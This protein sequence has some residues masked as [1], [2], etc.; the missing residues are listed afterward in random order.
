MSNHIWMEEVLQDL[1]VYCEANQLR[2]TKDLLTAA[3]KVL[4]TEGSNDDPIA[5]KVISLNS[6]KIKRTTH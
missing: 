2:C 4:E 3:S 5:C 1:E 6:P